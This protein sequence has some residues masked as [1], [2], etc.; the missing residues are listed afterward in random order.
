MVEVGVVEVR[1]EIFLLPYAGSFSFIAKCGLTSCLL[2]CSLPLLPL[3]SWV[4]RP[5][6][7]LAS[8][9]AFLFGVTV[10]LLWWRLRRNPITWVLGLIFDSGPHV[11]LFGGWFLCVLAAVAVV[12]SQ[13]DQERASTRVRKYFH[14]LMVFV[15]TTGV[16][17]DPNFL[18]LSTIVAVSVFALL[19][20][21]RV[22]KVVQ[23]WKGYAYLYYGM[24]IAH[25]IIIFTDPTL[26]YFPEQLLQHISGREGSWTTDTHAHLLALRML[27]A[28]VDITRSF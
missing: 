21:I 10:P 6:A 7:F 8:G 23:N 9:L 4:G 12:G 15:H 27:I 28:I 3:T 11:A 1:H 22:Y 18:Y 2:F 26:L 13:P 20:A 14:L 16:L 19:E 5:S 25:F 17:V 24:L